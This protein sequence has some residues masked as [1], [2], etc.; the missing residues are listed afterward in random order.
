[1]KK[2]NIFIE[3]DGSEAILPMTEQSPADIYRI[4]DRIKVYVVEVEKQISFQKL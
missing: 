3:F 1:M 2:R 4:N